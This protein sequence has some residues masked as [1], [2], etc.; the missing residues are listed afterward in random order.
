M[1]GG[2]SV[3]VKGAARL[4]ATMAQAARELGNVSEPSARAGSVLLSRARGMAPRR[5]GRLSG[6]LTA[7]PGRNGFDVSSGL[8]YGPPI[9]W[10]WAGHGIAAN[11][12][13]VRAVT[14]GEKQIVDVFAQYVDATLKGVKGI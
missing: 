14:T 5:S 13:L 2:A 9:H 12:F 11:P 7:T 4:A 10:G 6:S 1:A 3:E 8:V